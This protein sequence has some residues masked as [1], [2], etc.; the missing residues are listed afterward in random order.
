MEKQKYYVVVHLPVD[1]LPSPEDDGPTLDTLAE[2]KAHAI[3]KS[4]EGKH[5]YN[6]FG[7][8]DHQEHVYDRIARMGE[9]YIQER[10]HA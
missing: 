6:L 10:W 7:V 5:I 9:Y 1:H 3:P 2:A 4:S 8:F